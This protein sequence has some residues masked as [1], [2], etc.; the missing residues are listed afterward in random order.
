MK[1]IFMKEQSQVHCISKMA[2]V[3]KTSRSGYYKW[4]ITPTSN[5]GLEN[6]LLVQKIRIYQEELKYSYGSKRLTTHIKNV[7]KI[8]LG[9]NRVAKLMKDN[10]LGAKRKRRWRKPKEEKDLKST[11]PNIL[12]RNFDVSEP[13]KIWV[14]DIS[15]IRT[16]SG[17]KYLCAIM[18]LYSRKI[19]GWSFAHR[20]DMPLVLNAFQAAIVNRNH[21]KGVMFHTD[22]GSQYC[23]NEFKSVL[24]KNEFIQSMSRKGNCWDNACIESFFKSLKYEYLYPLGILNTQETKMNLFEYIEIF[25]N[26]KRIHTS[27]GNRSPEEYEKIGA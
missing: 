22:R 14:S 10:K 5:R 27:L 13:D 9:H 11:T 15:Y 1:Y 17:W 12:D 16:S 24:E 19:I 21:P 25:Y 2:R 3:L 26:R 4:L 6:E 7:E 18:D 8:A 20:M 23:S